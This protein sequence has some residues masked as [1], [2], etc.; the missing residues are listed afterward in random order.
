MTTKVYLEQ[1]N[2]DGLRELAR[3]HELDIRG[4]RAQVLDRLADHF[5]RSGRP[6]QIGL[7]DPN[8]MEGDILISEDA[9]AGANI[10]DR[11]FEA[12]HADRN[13]RRQNSERAINVQE[14]VQAVVQA[15]EASR[16]QSDEVRGDPDRAQRPRTP[17]SS[18]SQPMVLNQSPR[19]IGTKLNSPRN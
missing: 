11:E 17:S 6:E 18:G 7:A 9:G 19:I 5:E 3:Q 1:L 12:Q 2:F 13:L 16:F 15:L 8:V 4:T 10:Q 14:I